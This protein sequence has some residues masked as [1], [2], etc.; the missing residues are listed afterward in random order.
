MSLWRTV[1]DISM[2]ILLAKVS[3]SFLGKTL[4]SSWH[5]AVYSGV[6][7]INRNSTIASH[8]KE[9]LNV[10]IRKP[11]ND[12]VSVD[13]IHKN[14]AVLS[15]MWQSTGNTLLGGKK[16]LHHVYPEFA[17]SYVTQH[18][19][20]DMHVSTSSD[21][22]LRAN[23]ML[24]SPMTP[25]W[26][27]TF[28]DVDRSKLYSTFVSVWLGATTIDSPVW[29]PSG[30]TF[31]MLH[32]YQSH[33]NVHCELHADQHSLFYTPTSHRN[34]HNSTVSADIDS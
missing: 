14:T 29:I 9:L 1:N 5:G 19:K 8:F 25:R 33:I 28:T 27:I 13:V 32:T 17:D 11:G 15:N 34:T 3:P 2:S 6:S 16:E 30:S 12:W 31:S 22:G 23:W 24:H 10:V 18:V 21:S 4:R 7:S 26:R 20:L